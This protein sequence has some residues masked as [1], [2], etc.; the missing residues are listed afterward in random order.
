MKRNGIFKVVLLT[1]LIAIVCT[2]IFKAPTLTANGL[3]DGDRAQLGIFTISQYVEILFQY[4]FHIILIVVSMGAFYG[5]AYKIPAYRQLLDMLVEKARGKEEIVLGAIMAIIAIIV[6]VTGLQLGIMFVFPFVISLVVLMGYNKLVAASVTVGS[7][8]VGLIG[9]TLGTST[10]YYIDAVL[11]TNYATEMISKVALLV[12]A[13]AVLIFN[14][15]VYARKTRNETDKVLAYVPFKNGLPEEE[16]TAVKVKKTNIFSKI[17]TKKKTVKKEENKKENK[18]TVKKE[19]PKKET[20][21]TVKPTA[22]KKAPAKKSTKTRA[23]N[24]ATTAVKVVRGTGNAKIWPFIVV[25]DLTLLIMILSVFDWSLF[26]MTWAS[27]ALKSIKE[28]EVGEFPIFGKIL[29]NVNAFGQWSIRYEIPVLMFVSSGILALIYK[30][31][32]D[33]FIDGVLE[34]MKKTLVPALTMILA[35][36]VLIIC[37]EDAFQ[38]HFVRFFLELNKGLS[39][40]GVVFTMTLS[41]IVGSIVNVDTLY[42]AQIVLSYATT[43]ITD[44]S[45]YPI[46]GVMTQGIY[47]LMMLIA[48]TSLVLIGTLSFLNIPYLQWIKHIWKVFLELLGILLVIFL[49]LVLI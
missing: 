41:L 1:I 13:L 20:K 5:V 14:V 18:K 44:T 15:I 30:V 9:T 12:L 26:D 31:K 48:P 11:G 19:A 24:A 27:D 6:S 8:I 34:G 10:T 2:W 46:I 39:S 21:K 22:K 32:F 17:L 35:Y 47:G 43:I 28:F 7:T 16:V 4:F 33:D 3:V 23:N 38:L 40:I 37:V 29:G 49:I 25:F 45:L 36:L 42:L